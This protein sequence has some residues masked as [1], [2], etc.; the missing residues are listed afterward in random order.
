VQEAEAQKYS[1]PNFESTQLEKD[2]PLEDLFTFYLENDNLGMISNLGMRVAD[3]RGKLGPNDHV[4]KE[5][6]KFSAVAVDFAKHGLCVPMAEI[7]KLQ[8]QVKEIQSYYPDFGWNK[9][10]KKKTKKSTT[11]LGN[12]FRAVDTQSMITQCFHQEHK[13]GVR[14][15][16]ND[17]YTLNYLILS[18]LL[19]V[20]DL[21]ANLEL[22]QNKA[23]WRLFFSVLLQVYQRVVMPFE[24][25]FKALME[26][27][28]IAN[29]GELFCTDMQ[30]KF[31][32]DGKSAK[33]A[34][35]SGANKDDQAD[36]V[37]RKIKELIKRH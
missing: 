2:S 30:F 33:A 7:K 32:T 37:E 14:V 24:A 16:D 18:Y 28:Q 21:R 13:M 5:L 27:Q 17:S 11:V 10:K 35:D 26:Q 36:R 20:E 19:K 22:K 9:D 25:E 6:S 31:C 34:G 1:K 23:T 15:A 8:D 3:F 12:L 29:E 4:A